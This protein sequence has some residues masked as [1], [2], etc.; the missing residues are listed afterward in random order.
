MRLQEQVKTG[1][2]IADDDLRAKVDEFLKSPFWEVRNEAIKIIGLKKMENYIPMLIKF[3]RYPG[4]VGFIRR[5]ALSALCEIGK[6]TE[7]IFQL[8]V[9]ALDD[10]Y[11]EVRT[12]A[13]NL[14]TIEG[15][16]K[17]R[18]EEAL[19]KRFVANN[20]PNSVN[21]AEKDKIKL[22]EKNFEVL[23]AF[24]EAL[25]NAGCSEN[26]RIV[27]NLLCKNENW[28]VRKAALIALVKCLLSQGKNSSEIEKA[29]SEVDLIS[30]DFTPIF[31]LKETY[32]QLI[33]NLREKSVE[34]K[35]KR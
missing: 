31:P 11:W 33:K 14:L 16:D 3:A 9:S 6:T 2:D 27:L 21:P 17:K 30:Q 7:E 32:N 23:E 12:Q 26:T 28:K 13:C 18:S 34:K 20:S 19:L 35:D 24:A 22:K 8:A 10:P 1:M 5:N 29:L 4:E 25:G 15:F